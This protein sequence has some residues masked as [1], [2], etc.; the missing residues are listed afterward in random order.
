MHPMNFGP[1]WLRSDGNTSQISYDQAEMLTMCH[2]LHKPTQPPKYKMLLNPEPSLPVSLSPEIDDQ[3]DPVSE[4]KPEPETKKQ[5]V[6]NWDNLKYD[7]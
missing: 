4:V 3:I 2:D 1:S 5:Y 7:Y 6:S